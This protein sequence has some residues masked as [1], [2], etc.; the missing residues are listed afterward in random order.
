MARRRIGA[1]LIT[2]R[3][4]IRYLTGFRG[5]A[6]SVIVGCSG[7]AVLITDF[8]YREQAGREAPGARIVIQTKDHLT[9]VHEAAC[10]LRLD[11]LWFDESSLTVDRVRALRRKGLRLVGS[12]DLVADLR[13][14]KDPSELKALRR[15]IGRAEDAF[16]SLRRYIRPGMT[17]RELSL[18]LE[19]SMRQLGARR[20]AFDTIVASG[21][22]GAM[23]H[24]SISNR[25][26]RS[27]DL[28]TIDFGAEADGY[29]CD[30]TRTVAVG[31]ATARQ[32]AVHGLV[33]RAQQAAIAAIAPGAAGRDIDRMAR[34]LIAAE[35]HGEHFGH[36][37]GHGIGL[38]VHEGPSLSSLSKDRLAAGMVVT[39]E[40]GVYV[41]G[42]GGVRIEDMVLVTERGPKVLTTLPRD[43]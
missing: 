29:Y 9:A 11:R 20:A 26:L 31:P 14:Q 1:L 37:T 18:R 39:V 3:E 4:N 19:W 30:L 22:N 36:A 23:P 28:V 35:G 16:R 25:R 41:P 34:D 33:L 42:W 15:A 7:R 21:R 6:G 12:R 17:E 10:G 43:L 27:G 24:A 13:R 5:S 2:Q 40:P 8:R 38:Q 32:R